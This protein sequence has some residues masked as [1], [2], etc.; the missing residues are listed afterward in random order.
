M[1]GRRTTTLARATAYPYCPRAS[2]E[3]R[4]ATTNA[5]TNVVSRHRPSP[6]YMAATLIKIRVFRNRI[7]LV[8]FSLNGSAVAGQQFF[9]P[10][11]AVRA[12]ALHGAKALPSE[13]GQAEHRAAQH[14]GEPHVQNDIG[15]NGPLRGHGGGQL[16]EVLGL[17]R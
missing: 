1:S 5:I 16:L 6:V 14:S 2:A 10:F 13:G 17:R 9:C 15:A 4:R 7:F 3:K 8:V 12:S 11:N